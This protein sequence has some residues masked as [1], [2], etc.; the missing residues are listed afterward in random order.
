[1]LDVLDVEGGV[2]IVPMPS[3]A[4]DVDALADVARWAYEGRY[5]HAVLVAVPDRQL[6]L[7]PPEATERLSRLA[8]FVADGAEVEAETDRTA[9]CARRRGDVT[10]AMELGWR[11]GAAEIV[12]FILRGLP[13][14]RS[15]PNRSK[16]GL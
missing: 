7:G 2:S 4:F 9:Y 5:V 12:E 10:M 13:V 8:A 6:R 1:V 15:A 14:A 11:E 3:E 16:R